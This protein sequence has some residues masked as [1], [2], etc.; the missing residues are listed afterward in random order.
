MLRTPAPS[1]HKFVFT[2]L[3]VAGFVTFA[4]A[5][6]A[7]A[8]VPDSTDG[9]SVHEGTVEEQP[10]TIVTD[11]PEPEPTGTEIHEP[12]ATETTEPE[13]T[14]TPTP[15]E[16]DRPTSTTEPSETTGE[17]TTTTPAE[18]TEPEPTTAEPEPEEPTTPSSPIEKPNATENAPATNADG[19]GGSAG[20]GG[21]AVVPAE[22]GNGGA[23]QPRTT[24][25]DA[26]GQTYETVPAG[27]FEDALK[28]SADKAGQ[29][30]TAVADDKEIVDTGAGLNVW[31]V[32]WFAAA[33]ALAGVLL[34]MRLRRKA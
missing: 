20:N 25:T 17:P 18:T 13:E 1:W 32:G 16:T 26:P 6:S 8:D 27:A 12:P 34:R 24:V 5:L 31:V 22:P 3:V 30:E 11:T 33:L 2:S 23:V 7:A 14:E 9:V 19:G 21:G 28:I 29:Q 15:T 4:P 10:G